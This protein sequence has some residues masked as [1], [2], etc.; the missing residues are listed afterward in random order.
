MPAWVA[1]HRRL[2][3]DTNVLIYL[4]ENH[5]RYGPWC[6]ALFEHIEQGRAE[7][8][9]STVSLLE[10]LVQPY[11]LQDEDMARKV[12]GLLTTYPGLAWSPVTIEI[13][14][15]GADLRARYRLSTPDAIQVATAIEHGATLFVGNDKGLRKV[16]EIRCAVL[17]D[18]I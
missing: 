12:Y 7:A 4:L 15:K 6:A 1:E 2:G 3:L 8:V 9:T 11:R 5:P 16:K 14:D 17:D 13:A 10:I 18:L